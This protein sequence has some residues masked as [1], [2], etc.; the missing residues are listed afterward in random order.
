MHISIGWVIFIYLRN[1]VLIDC[2]ESLSNTTLKRDKGIVKL[3]TSSYGTRAR[4]WKQPYLPVH[5]V[6]PRKNASIPIPI[7]MYTWLS[8]SSFCYGATK[9]SSGLCDS[10]FQRFPNIFCIQAS[11]SSTI[12][13]RYSVVMSLALPFL[14]Y[15]WSRLTIGYWVEFRELAEDEVQGS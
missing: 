6:V 1:S 13:Y 4:W 12:G 5:I 11:D 8:D 10:F 3:S 9:Y 14:P 2:L 7:L 15:G